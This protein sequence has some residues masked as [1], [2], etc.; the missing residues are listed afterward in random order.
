MEMYRRKEQEKEEKEHEM[1][2]TAE[3]T[4]VSRAALESGGVRSRER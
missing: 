2:I 1:L 4:T 3:L